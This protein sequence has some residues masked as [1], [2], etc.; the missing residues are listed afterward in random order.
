[1]YV[2]MYVC[3]YVYS[4]CMCEVSMKSV[5]IN[6]MYKCLRQKLMERICR[7]NVQLSR[8]LIKILRIVHKSAILGEA[9]KRDMVMKL[10]ILKI[11][12]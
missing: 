6:T 10:C 12:Q 9:N 2:C 1:M 7:K 5:P 3:M 4:T 11:L 8:I